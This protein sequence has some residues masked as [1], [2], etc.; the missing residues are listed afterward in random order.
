MQLLD[1]LKET[2]RYWK[3][4]I[5]LDHTVWRTWYGRG[6]GPVVRQYMERITIILCVHE[7]PPAIGPVL[8]CHIQIWI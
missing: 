3:K 6:P 4:E 2:R 1:G 5:A 8:L 7:N